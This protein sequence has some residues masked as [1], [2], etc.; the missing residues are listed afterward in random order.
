[1]DILS[2][3]NFTVASSTK[4]AAYPDE[5]PESLEETY[6]CM[7]KEIKKPNRDYAVI[8]FHTSSWL[9]GHL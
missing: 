8:Y 1:M 7:L 2:V 5:L 4:C 9:S 3:G 6:E